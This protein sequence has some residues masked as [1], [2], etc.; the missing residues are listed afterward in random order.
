MAERA[1]IEAVAR[2]MGGP[3]AWP[4]FL[5]AAAMAI[6]AVDR[7]RDARGDDEAARC[8]C[9][10][11]VGGHRDECPKWGDAPPARFPQG[12]D[13]EAGIRAML[14]EAE[15]EDWRTIARSVG[16]ASA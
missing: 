8:G 6:E 3:A 7:V 2:E 14:A 13:H 12:E 10:E 15:G 9:N 16:F 5:R 11:L 4:M 1:E